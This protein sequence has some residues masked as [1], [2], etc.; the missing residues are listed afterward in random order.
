MRPAPP[1]PSAAAPPGLAVLLRKDWIALRNL[2]RVLRRQPRLKVWFIT[3]FALGLVG[4]LYALFLDG[5]RFLDSLGGAGFL[6]TRRLF[7]VFYLALGIMLALSSVV[8]AYA[9]LFR[10]RD[11]PFL[12]TCPFGAET[13]AT[14]KFLQS[15]AFSSWAFVFVI[16]PFAAAYARHER[17]GLAFCGWTA[18]YA[19]PFLVLCSGLGVLAGLTAARWCPRRSV[20][21]V[22]VAALVLGAGSMVW[23]G[24]WTADPDAEPAFVLS[25]I[26]P[27]LRAAANPFLPSW[28]AAEGVMACTRGHWGRGLM[29]W[30]VLLSNTWM[31]TL[32][33]REV[34]RH[35]YPAA[36][37]RAVGGGGAARRRPVL[38]AGLERLAGAVLPRDVRG[39]VL[40]DLRTVLRDPAQWSQALIFFGLLAL[41]FANIRSFYTSRLPADWRNLVAFLNVFSVASVQCSLASRFIYPQL[42][43]EGQAFWVLGLSPTRMGRILAVKFWLA[44]AGML[45]VS[46]G[47]MLV[48]TAM[49]AVSPAV[50]LAAVGLAAAISIA[51]SGLSTGLGA[52]FMDLKSANPMAAVSGFGG[53]VNLVLSL[54]FMLAVILP[55]GFVFQLAGAGRITPAGLMRGLVA[56]GCWTLFLTVAA[57]A[58]PLRLGRRALERRDY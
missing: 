14:Y 34:G 27:G 11:V 51:V 46:V 12:M 50:R 41:Y 7:A 15:T 1:S 47:L 37:R 38:L 43:L 30:L 8:T 40:K 28:W 45:T 35:A 2:G 39:M 22:P 49:L 54:G 10:S 55:A 31:L 20:V 58:V 21:W 29:L 44:L 36:W 52:V 16:L 13:L 6:I 24:D 3:L 5:F 53:T 56:V 32:L 57:A 9:T 4:G 26:A 48:S 23:R 19:A 25:R 17:L 42:S 18:L 33:V